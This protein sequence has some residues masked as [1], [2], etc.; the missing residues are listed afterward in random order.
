MAG[1]SAC[2]GSKG[3]GAG[4]KS[5]APRARKITSILNPNRHTEK[6]AREE[7][8][9]YV[10]ARA[11]CARAPVVRGQAVCRQR[12]CV[13]KVAARRAVVQVYA[14]AQAR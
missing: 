2:G 3:S 7:E 1:S 4:K 5:R 6:M 11:W 10:A 14:G 12:V 8:T 13:G 9:W